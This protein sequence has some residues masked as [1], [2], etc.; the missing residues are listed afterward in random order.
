[1]LQGYIQS[2]QQALSSAKSIND[3]FGPDGTTLVRSQ[4][5]MT[6]LG[7]V[8][9]VVIDYGDD[10]SKTTY[11]FFYQNKMIQSLRQNNRDIFTPKTDLIMA[12]MLAVEPNHHAKTVAKRRAWH[13]QEAMKQREAS[14]RRM[15]E[16]KYA[17]S[18]IDVFIEH[19]MSAMRTPSF[20][21]LGKLFMSIV[22]DFHD[23]IVRTAF[24]EEP[25]RRFRTDD[26]DM[27]DIMFNTLCLLVPKRI[28][29]NH[30]IDKIPM[31]VIEDA[32]NDVTKE[33]RIAHMSENVRH[34]RAV[35]RQIFE[36]CNKKT[37]LLSFVVDGLLKYYEAKKGETVAV[38]I[39]RENARRRGGQRTGTFGSIAE[40]FPTT[41]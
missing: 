22:V 10:P 15:L 41:K 8:F 34:V 24:V 4:K 3:K 27:Q 35:L 2:L 12:L 39:G 9:D 14:W 20:E 33:S 21:Y 11:Q 6:Y 13:N 40:L 38:R 1:M 23:E 31:F 29:T 17:D 28:K 25:R 30:G 18:I 37:A 32:F 16:G 7:Y 5:K 26:Y 19:A 36:R